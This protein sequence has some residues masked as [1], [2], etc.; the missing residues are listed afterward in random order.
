M[1]SVNVFG[2]YTDL[3][4]RAAGV[5]WGVGGD[6]GGGHFHQAEICTLGGCIGLVHLGCF[7]TQWLSE[8]SVSDDGGDPL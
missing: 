5:G 2:H 1:K 7:K 8:S 6:G 4:S 3:L